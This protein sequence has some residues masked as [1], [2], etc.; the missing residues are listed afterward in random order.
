MAHIFSNHRNVLKNI[1]IVTGL[2]ILKI[3]FM[4][5]FL[6]SQECLKKSLL[7]SLLI[8]ILNLIPK[9]TF[10]GSY[11]LQ[12]PECLK[13]KSIVT[14]LVILKIQFMTHIFKS[15]ERLKKIFYCH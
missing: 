6:K 9:N 7:T 2:V 3:P 1:Y 13:K 4:A 15:Q 5:H 14:R 12:L 10:Y 8:S 11:F